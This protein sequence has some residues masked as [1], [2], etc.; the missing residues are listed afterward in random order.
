MGFLLML[1]LFLNEDF[2]LMYVHLKYIH[3]YMGESRYIL[4][5]I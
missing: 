5:L 3:V 2:F 4:F 1:W